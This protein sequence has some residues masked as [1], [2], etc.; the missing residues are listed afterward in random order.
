[1]DSV[2]GTRSKRRQ[3]IRTGCRAAA[4]RSQSSCDEISSDDDEEPGRRK[5]CFLAFTAGLETRSGAEAESD[6][7][8]APQ[9]GDRSP[10]S[11]RK[12]QKNNRNWLPNDVRVQLPAASAVARDNESSEDVNLRKPVRHMTPYSVS[13]EALP[14]VMVEACLFVP[15]L[16]RQAGSAD[17]RHFTFYGGHTRAQYREFA[18]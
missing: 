3:E 4:V 15:T 1:M 7:E 8:P 16:G 6:D 18:A 5:R 10:D 2:I 17:C 11:F 12:Q 14:K 13:Q 9:R